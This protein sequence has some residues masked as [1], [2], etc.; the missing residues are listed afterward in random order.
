MKGFFAVALVA[1]LCAAP[2][3]AEPLPRPGYGGVQT[4]PAPLPADLRSSQTRPFD[5]PDVPSFQR[6]QIQPQHPSSFKQTKPLPRPVTLPARLPQ[7]LKQT[8]PVVR[9][10]VQPQ[11][12]VLPA[13]L[14]SPGRQT[15]PLARPVTLP[16]RL[17][18]GFRQTRPVARPSYHRPQVLPAYPSGGRQTLPAKLPEDLRGPSKQTRPVVRPTS[19]IPQ[20]ETE[21]CRN[22]AQLSYVRRGACCKR[23][24]TCC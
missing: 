11:P 4:L 7:D 8:R 17:P 22:C 21:I 13:G 19:Y 9:P 23:W 18:E 2:L 16:A 20:G 1:V 3:R 5:R 24:N 14:S 12:V 15:K 6:P 10:Q